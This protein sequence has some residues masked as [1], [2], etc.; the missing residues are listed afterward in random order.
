[1]SITNFILTTE[2]KRKIN[3]L[4]RAYL[5]AKA[6]DDMLTNVDSQNVASR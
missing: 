2:Q 4:Q 1:M 5:Q 3:A 6:L